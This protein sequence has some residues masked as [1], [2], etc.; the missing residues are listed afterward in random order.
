MSPDSNTTP[1]RHSRFLRATAE[2]GSLMKRMMAGLLCYGLLCAQAWSQYQ[3]VPPAYTS[4][5]GNVTFLGPLSNAQRTYQLL[6]HESQLT[7]LV[8]RQLGGISWRLPTSATGPW[9]AAEVV[10]NNYDVFLSGGV[11]PAARSLTDFSANVVGT[12][13]QVRAGSLSVHPNAYPSGGSPNT[14]GPE[15][16]FDTP[17]LYTGGHLLVEI[18]HDGFSG[19]SRSADA[20]GTSTVGYGSQFSACWVGS[21]TGNS[22]SQGNFSVVRFTTLPQQ[23]TLSV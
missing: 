9:P 5:P 17:W 22:G 23:P 16:T 7:D 6:I 1:I 2:K 20:I 12:R 15:I 18:R 19:T 3:V 21:Y 4:A 8:G 14:F 13:T 10:F 11:T